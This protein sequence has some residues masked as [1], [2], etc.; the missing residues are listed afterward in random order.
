MTDT[1]TTGGIAADRL[2]SI[3]ERVERLEE[4]R[5]ALGSD[6]RDIFTEAKSAGFDVKVIKEI[7]KIRKQEPAEVEEQEQLLDIYRRALG[8]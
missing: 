2:R 3:V 1:H 7:I 5:K 6:I 4:E 8:V